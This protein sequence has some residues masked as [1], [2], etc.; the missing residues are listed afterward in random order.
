MWRESS[1][2]DGEDTTDEWMA[3]A[4]QRYHDEV[5]R[6]V[7][8]D[9]LLVWSVEEGWEPLCEFLDVPVPD[10]PFPRLN[11]SAQFGERLIDAAL[12]SLQDWRAKERELVQ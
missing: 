5:K 8:A 2:L 10:T 9:R 1:L 3:N 6:T 11:D 12:I 7:P 4:A